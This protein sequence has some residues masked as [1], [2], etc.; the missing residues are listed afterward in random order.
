MYEQGLGKISR[1][2]AP[3]GWSAATAGLAPG[4]FAG[5]VEAG[6]EQLTVIGWSDPSDAYKGLSE[7]YMKETGNKAKYLEGSAT[8]PD[9]VAKYT[10]YLKSGYDKIDVR[11]IDDFPVGNVFQRSE[12]VDHLAY[13]SLCHSSTPQNGPTS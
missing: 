9:L 4:V 7:L 3:K 11:L 8:Y 6:S 12:P 10:D 1:R 5:G 2:Q 13:G